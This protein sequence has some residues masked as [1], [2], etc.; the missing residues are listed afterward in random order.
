MNRFTLFH[1][2]AIA[3][4]ML[5]F[6]GSL[7]FAAAAAAQ[8]PEPDSS[9]VPT[10]EEVTVSMKK[11]ASF[12][13]SKLAYGGGYASRWSQ[14]L[15]DVYG[16]KRPGSPTQIMIQPPGTTSVGL[17]MLKAYQVTGDR[18]FLQG[19][20][21][22][23]NALMWCQLASGGWSG[24][25]DFARQRP[26]SLRYRRD[27]DAGVIDPEDRIAFSTLDDNKTQSALLLLLELAN[28]PAC[29]RDENLRHALNFGL[30]GL[31]A[32]QAP[33]G[34]WPQQY[35]GA[36]QGAA[37]ALKA[38]FSTD[39]SRVFPDADYKHYYTLNDGVFLHTI[40]LL[41]RARELEKDERFLSAA[42]K[43]G[44]FL[45]LAQLPEP[46]PIWAQQYNLQMEPAWARKFEPPAACSR[47]SLGA[48]QAL[49]ELS[50]VTG[51][52]RYR[53][54]LTAALAWFERSNLDGDP[55]RWARFYELGAN[56]PIYCEAD[57]Y[58]ITRES[59]NLPTHYTYILG[60][61]FGEEL[62]TFRQILKT[63][64]S[65]RSDRR[66]DAEKVT[67]ALQSQTDAGYWLSE[68]GLIDA[69]LFVLNFELMCEYI[70]S[71]NSSPVLVE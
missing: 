54:P 16:E 38:S 25:Y 56:Q 48:M 8:E 64:I 6:T 51:E 53:E 60:D 67:A 35:N 29:A 13:R 57:T 2:L 30:E 46:H 65:S 33:S 34:G 70:S 17:A 20:R 63:G 37:P 27:V 68:G 44:D 19:A 32:A 31:L 26:S 4:V 18:L 61:A 24:S 49:Y 43:A 71:F 47:E 14:D 50:L 69:G 40:R 10:V 52:E 62:G 22:A 55:D 45:L 15:T 58:V 12:Y 11:A 59:S 36:H 5:P 28:T 3:A 66:I 42:Q 7:V 9:P 23:A 1:S 21:E 39:W 41:L